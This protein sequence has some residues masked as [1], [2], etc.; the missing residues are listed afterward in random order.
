MTVN[1][2]LAKLAAAFPAFNAQ[3][4]EA[5]APVYRARLAKHEGPTLT[6]AYAET[7]GRFTVKSS[8]A[9]FPVPADFEA[10]LP[11][12]KV[13]L[14]KDS[15]PK[16][17]LEG[18]KRRAD[19]LFADWQAGQCRRADKGNPL[20]RR[21][22]EHIARHVADVMGWKENP[23]PLVLTRD[24]LKA[25]CQAALSQERRN[26]FGQPPKDKHRW[27]QQISSVAVEWGIECTPEWWDKKT[28]EALAPGADDEPAP[29]PRV[30]A[31]T[32]TRDT[33][34]RNREAQIALIKANI[35]FL[36]DMGILDGI[37]AKE[38]ELA[39][40]EQQSEAA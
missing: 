11:T 19:A 20:L 29:A 39:Q 34:P 4:A 32:F 35:R 33:P 38:R 5:W 21:S 30:T 9:L 7:L 3:A 2:L 14:G 17:D 12:G 28:G 24:Q 16:L 26:R 22:L 10:H 36:R 18:R 1:E 27:W 23:E 6:S 31:A 15:G 40:L 13:D 25:A 8:K 37:P